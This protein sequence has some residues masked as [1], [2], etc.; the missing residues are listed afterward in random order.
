M[1]HEVQFISDP[2]A[3]FLD[4]MS[5]LMLGQTMSELGL[6]G[7][8]M[9]PVGKHYVNAGYGEKAKEYVD[10]YFRGGARPGR[11]SDPAPTNNPFGNY[12]NA[13]L[14]FPLPTS[15]ATAQ[16]GMK[17]LGGLMNVSYDDIINSLAQVRN[18]PL[19]R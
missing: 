13:P 16:P 9:G 4:M 12:P 6:Y 18:N 2:Q 11:G 14:T 19:G 7:Q 1:A 5:E 17:P 15:A 8:D 3:F 10:K